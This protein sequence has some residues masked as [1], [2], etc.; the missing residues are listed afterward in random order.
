LPEIVRIGF[1]VGL[2]RGSSAA[3]CDPA[4]AIRA[5]KAPIHVLFNF[6]VRMEPSKKLLVLFKGYNVNI[7]FNPR[8]YITQKD[9]KPHP[10]SYLLEEN[11][12]EQHQGFTN[13]GFSKF[14]ARIR[15]EDVQS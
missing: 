2:G 5:T 13:L 11:E 3:A 9:H 15:P 8:L 6:A 12:L 14:K 10:K 1:P 7:Y 4:K